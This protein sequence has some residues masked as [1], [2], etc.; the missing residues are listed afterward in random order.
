MRTPHGYHSVP[1]YARP[2]LPDHG[3]SLACRQPQTHRRTRIRR[4][5][6][7]GSRP[8]RSC[9]A[10]GGCADV[11]GAPGGL[12]PTGRTTDS[13]TS[14]CRQPC[15]R[16]V[17][18]ISRRAAATVVVGSRGRLLPALVGAHTVDDMLST[19]CSVMTASRSGCAICVSFATSPRLNERKISHVEPNSCWQ[20]WS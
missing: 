10:Q 1:I 6:G 5:P 4:H 3:R 16:P 11:R 14:L 12:R 7:P 13:A 2:V 20:S 17:S 18:S 19:R 8:R 15:P 9:L